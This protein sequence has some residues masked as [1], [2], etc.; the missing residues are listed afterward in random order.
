MTKILVTLP[1]DD[2]KPYERNPRKNDS[3]VADLME[4]IKQTGYIAPIIVDE[5]N[6]ILAGHTRYKALSA[7]GKKEALVLQVRGMTKDQ[8]KK[9]RLLDNK[10]SEKS[11]W[12]F[13]LLDWELEE[14]D[15]EGY[16]FGFSSGEDIDID[17]F[18]GE[19]EDDE[20]EEKLHE[21]ICPHCGEKLYINKS[22][23]V[24]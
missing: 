21:I 2:I 20:D 11:G 15:W 3:A 1:L 12:D 6:V 24:K 16:D 14:I 8:K 18:F 4:S 17:N 9:Y 23:E 19:S 22:F 7:L 10:I 13:E 5:D